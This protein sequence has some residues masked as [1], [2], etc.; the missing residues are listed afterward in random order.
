[1]AA[2]EG[3]AKELLDA[4]NYATV[5]TLRRDGSVHTVVVWVDTDD[6]NAVLNSSEGRAWPRNLE[7]DPRVTINVYDQS[8]PYEYVEV[9]GRVA[10]ATLGEEADRNID[11]LAKKYM[12]VNEYPYRQPGEV[13]IKYVVAADNI[14]HV[15]Q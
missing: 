15:A 4:P 3:R 7:R 13:R 9:R 1:M 5:S 8:N 10:D 12:G 11:E 6:G 2:L 14:R